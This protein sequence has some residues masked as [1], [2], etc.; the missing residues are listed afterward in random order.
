MSQSVVVNPRPA[1]KAKLTKEP[2]SIPNLKPYYKAWPTAVNP[3][4]P[5]LKVA[6]EARIKKCSF[7]HYAIRALTMLTFVVSI[8]L[9][10]R[11]S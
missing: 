6:L 5:G 2:F 11:Q 10:R 1:L 3:N 7:Y 8:P 4:Y 9:R